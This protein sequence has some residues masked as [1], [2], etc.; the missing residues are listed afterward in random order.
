MMKNALLLS[1]VMALALAACGEDMAEK[2]TAMPSAEAT[3]DTP[4][5]TTG[6]P[7][8]DDAS[9]LTALT[10]AV[11]SSA[12]SEAAKAR[13]AFR[14]PVETLMF[15]GVKP[16]DTVVEIWPGGGWYTDIIAPYLAS[17]G[18]K[19][20]AAG[21]DPASDNPRVLE[22][23]QSFEAKYVANPDTYGEVEMSVLA[24]SRQEIAPSGS[25]DVVVTFRNIHNFEM[26]GWAPAAFAAFYDALKPGGTLGVVEHRLPEDADKALEKSSG[27]VKVSTV[28]QLAEDAGFVFDGSSEI[29]ANP[30][31]DTDHP[32]G[33]WTLPPNSRTSDRDG[34]APEGF[35]P[36]AYLAIGESDRMTQRVGKPVA[37][38]EALLE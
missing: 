4:A 35:D 10:A 29:N 32:F 1:S 11:Q 18:G 6:A 28:R 25:A 15:F 7:V 2:T 26:G 8:A 16:G 24:P 34:N 14:H 23:L 22:A 36:A 20:Y 30:A 17:G 27:Y 31:D 38:E 13:D 9:A 19:L 21:F 12:R 33:V 3:A 5:E 37:P